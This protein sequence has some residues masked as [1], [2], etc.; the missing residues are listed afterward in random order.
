M[1]AMERTLKLRTLY[2]LPRGCQPVWSLKV[3]R[4]DF[5][6]L[7]ERRKKRLGLIWDC[8]CGEALECRVG[9]SYLM[10]IL[11]VEYSRTLR[12]DPKVD[13]ESIFPHSLNQKLVPDSVPT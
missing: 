5:K 11:P 10:T 2:S 13:K 3:V 7:G 6:V 1:H 4:D 12:S 8:C 9:L